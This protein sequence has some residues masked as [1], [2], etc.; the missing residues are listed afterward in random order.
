M[1]VAITLCYET[2]HE[3]RENKRDHSFF[4]RS[5]TESLSC[6][7]K[8]GAPAFLQPCSFCCDRTISLAY[9]G[10]TQQ[11]WHC[12]DTDDL[13]SGEFV[14]FFVMVGKTR[15][16]TVQRFNA[17]FSLWSKKSIAR[18]YL[19]LV[20]SYKSLLDILRYASYGDHRQNYI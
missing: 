12:P 1:G 10:C 19:I 18:C 16:A 20:R 8:F 9:K 15:L 14:S 3:R 5:E 4:R 13:K 7:I 2:E 11:Q 6:L 17:L